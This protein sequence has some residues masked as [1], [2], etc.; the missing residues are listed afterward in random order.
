ARLLVIDTAD[1]VAQSV[2]HIGK[3]SGSVVFRH[4]LR[5][6]R[7]SFIVNGKT[8]NGLALPLQITPLVEGEIDLN[9]Q[10][11]VF[12]QKRDPF[13]RPGITYQATMDAAPLK[14]RVE[15]LPLAGATRGFTGAIGQ[16][17]V[18]QPRLSST[19]IM[20]GE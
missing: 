1:E 3:S 13:G 5:G 9:C 2:M 8:Y 6:A 19:E 11:I 12:V 14:F 18:S 15:P 7:E 16:F 4:Q 20:E 17:S 10:A